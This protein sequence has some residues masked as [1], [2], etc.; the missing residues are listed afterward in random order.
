MQRHA[1]YITSY[2]NVLY[3]GNCGRFFVTFNNG[4]WQWKYVETIEHWHV[5]HYA[6]KN[7]PVAV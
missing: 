4:L 3:D 2:S 7:P 1:K 5:V 6:P